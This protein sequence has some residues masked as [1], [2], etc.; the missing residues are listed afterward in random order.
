MLNANHKKTL[1]T[2]KVNYAGIEPFEPQEVS[3]KIA[4]MLISR[5]KAEVKM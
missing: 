4:E 3:D 2:V 5:D 1:R